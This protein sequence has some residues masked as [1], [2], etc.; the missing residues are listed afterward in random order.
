MTD[1]WTPSAAYAGGGGGGVDPTLAHYQDVGNRVRVLTETSP[2]LADQ[3]DALMAL[4]Q[5]ATLDTFDL[6][7]QSAAMTARL[8]IDTLAS[9]LT[10]MSAPVQRSVWGK[11]TETQQRALAEL[12]YSRPERDSNRWG[13]LGPVGAVAGE[14]L[15][16]LGTAAGAAGGPV[17]DALTFVGDQSAHMYRTVAAM[18]EREQQ[19]GLFAG[20]LAATGIAAAPF[21]G[22]LSLGLT[23]AAVGGGGLLAANAAVAFTNP[24]DWWDSFNSTWDGER[25]FSLEAQRKAREL[26]G[27]DPTLLNLAADIGWN[28]DPYELVAEFAAGRDATGEN[29]LLR[30]V[31]RVAQQMLDPS[32]P[33][34]RQLTEGLQRLVGD[35][36]FH[37]AIQT[38][39]DG[40]ISF[41][42]SIAN[43]GGLSP[44]SGMYNVVS[45]AADGLWL[46]TMDPTLALGKVG[47]W[48]KARRFGVGI[49]GDMTA[50]AASVVQRI[51]NN[52]AISRHYDVL[53]DAVNTGDF[54][55]VKQMIPS[56]QPLWGDLVARRNALA[57]DGALRGGFTSDDIYEWLESG[58]GMISLL[59]GRAAVQGESKL[60]LPTLTRAG[61]GWGRAKAYAE[62][63]INFADD[64][65]SIAAMRK[66]AGEAE[67]DLRVTQTAATPDAVLAA[68]EVAQPAYRTG[69]RVASQADKYARTRAIIDVIDALPGLNKIE[70]SFG[71]LAGSMTN[72]IPPSRAI[73]LIDDA[74]HSATADIDKFVDL[75]RVLGMKSD[76]RNAWRNFIIDQPNTALRASAIESYLD[77]VL[78]VTGAGALPEGDALIK[79]FLTKTH[80]SYA[81]GGADQLVVGGR[82]RNTG[83]LPLA[84]QAVE[85]IMPDLR[86]LRQAVQKGTVLH[87]LLDAGDA[88]F[89]DSAMTKVWK[90][91]VLLRIGFIPR[92]AGEELLA[93]FARSG[94]S[95]FLAERAQVSVAQG[96]LT[97]P[98][99]YR[100]QAGREILTETDLDLMS[101]W[102]VA[103]HV[104]PLERVLARQDWGEPVVRMLEDYSRTL[105]GLLDDGIVSD[106]LLAR[107]PDAAREK[108]LG[109]ERGLRRLLIAGADDGIQDAVQAFQARFGDSIMRTVGAQNAGLLDRGQ[110]NLVHVLTEGS[111][112]PKAYVMSRG[113]WRHYDK[114]DELYNTAYHHQ[115]QRAFGDPVVAQAVIDPMTR[116]RP[117]FADLGEDAAADLARI[118]S[119]IDPEGPVARI[120]REGLD[121]APMSGIEH[122]RLLQELS[123]HLDAAQ[124]DEMAA[125][126]PTS[127][128]TAS[129]VLDALATVGGGATDEMLAARR[130]LDGLDGLGVETR[131]WAQAFLEHGRWTTDD[132]DNIGEWFIDD[133]DDI[134]RTNLAALLTDPDNARALQSSMFTV[135][136]PTGGVVRNP[137][138]N[139]TVRLYQPTL[140]QA[141][142]ATIRNVARPAARQYE[143]ALQADPDTASELL[144]SLAGDILQ[145]W[146]PE[147]ARLDGELQDAYDVV[148][149]FTKAMILRSGDGT[150]DE[151]IAGAQAV[152]H[153]PLAF[154]GFDDPAIARAV[155]FYIKRR[156]RQSLTNARNSPV[157][158]VDFDSAMRAGRL[159]EVT[160]RSGTG[161]RNGWSTD[162]NVV[163]HRAQMV[164]ADEEFEQIAGQWVHGTSLEESARQWS[165]TINER[166][167][168]I[169]RSDG[170]AEMR[171]VKPL[172]YQVRRRGGKREWVEVNPGQ[173]LSKDRQYIDADGK[174]VK[175]SDRNYMTTHEVEKADGRL[176]W[177]ILGP[178]LRDA[179]DEITGSTLAGPAGER[180][181][182]SK[183]AHIADAN[184]DL[185]QWAIDVAMKPVEEGKWDRFVRF[186]YDQVISP[187]IDAIVR[188]PMALHYWIDSYTQASKA[189]RWMRDKRII[190]D[191]L[192]ARFGSVFSGYAAEGGDD[193]M[194]T[195]RDGIALFDDDLADFTDL[196]IARYVA[197]LSDV[198]LDRLK[199]RARHR[200][201]AGDPNAGRQVATINAIRNADPDLLR[202]FARG[203]DP[204]LGFARM[205]IDKAGPSLNVSWSTARRHNRVKELI[206][207]Y[208]G[209]DEA[210]SDGGWELVKAA[211]DNL[212]HVDQLVGDI[213]I[214]RTVA[215]AM[216][217]VDSHAIKS[218]FSAYGRN[219][220]PFWYAE[221]NFIK[222]WARTLRIAPEALRK[223]QL[224][225]MGMKEVG[226]IRSDADGR[227]WFVYPGSGPFI[228]A[229]GKVPG[230]GALPIGA[231]MQAETQNMLPGFNR[232][233]QPSPSPLVGVPLTAITQ[234]FPELRPMHEAIA[235]EKGTYRGIARQVIPTT[236]MRVWEAFFADENTSTAYASA[237]NAAIAYME[238]AGNGVPDNA[239]AA[240]IDDFMRRV[241]KHARTIMFAQA[242]GG[243]IVPGSPRT[244]NTGTPSL[245]ESWTGV[246]ADDP[247][248]LI[249]EEYYTLIRQMG[250]EEGTAA[251]LERF[252]DHGLED[253]INPMALTVSQSESTSGA[254]LPATE[255]A[256]A[257]YDEHAGWMETLPNAGPWLLPPDQDSTDAGEAYAYTRQTID[258]L[259]LRR[260]P[261]EYLRAIKFKEGGIEYFR[262]MDTRDKLIAA[263]EAAG[264]DVRKR[265]AQETWSQFSDVHLARHPVF[266]EEL[267]SSDGRLRRQRVLAEMRVAVADPEAPRA[268]HFDETRVAVQM[269]DAYQGA[270]A[271]LRMDRT[272]AG[273]ERLAQIKGA[274]D[275]TMAEFVVRYPHMESLWISV[276]RPEANL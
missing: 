146:A 255:Q 21:T 16:V 139:N 253:I 166:L 34:Y 74:K 245:V 19:I 91:A 207:Q 45:G 62:G 86:E 194:R 128:A 186:G 222:R 25:V 92:A 212:E 51:K 36:D 39:Q 200:L 99:T 179:G 195:V 66:I 8:R 236:G 239:G 191:M 23:A 78:R 267:Q 174:P 258:G 110:R 127:N 123:Y 58:E 268:W 88:K 49:T 216:Q 38:L 73:S 118:Y 159:P 272:N 242:I 22:G 188:K 205:L 276:L 176:M 273:Q 7:T 218:Q 101:H 211:R 185:P 18:D 144:D 228:E 227:D 42:R 217:F 10:S 96:A 50:D 76:V 263:A 233:G 235:G 5:D 167:G 24:T 138:P 231:M 143:A 219:F 125:I 29:Q 244:L 102:R 199:A 169:V 61:V 67:A 90:P 11:L 84:D 85:L 63:V 119:Q 71:A 95:Q 246:G 209:F 126:L 122:D 154:Y 247:S 210:M 105:R 181:F 32:D 220:L 41:G 250:I 2:W 79:R 178:A 3:P 1:S 129:E 274:Y 69:Q 98:D 147:V 100:R 256:V 93:H 52:P 114:G 145:G 193:F 259:R 270:I 65:N 252:P 265:L 269:F 103:A 168:Q 130:L 190:D 151:L 87:Y 116:A 135:E 260:T 12:G 53:A 204:N 31:D 223:G 215:A 196:Q 240:E 175:W 232:F 170:L 162:H 55:T 33:R 192:P 15:G 83:V 271:E 214:E 141:D 121:A 72:M 111:D 275:Q 201:T 20:V 133:V 14:G 164:P 189:S 107:L 161:G 56:S 132:L 224:T 197:D 108:L 43:R 266:A 165:D 229:L 177:E 213:A 48:N 75:G 27:N 173:R 148:H 109:N 104:R 4:A 106:G 9:S 68:S 112:E 60:M 226:A 6:A 203:D 54:A 97:D 248:A 182:R 158:Y 187:S 198:E 134:V 30:S 153:V 163:R 35:P 156:N 221:E 37:E 241:E 264:D 77:T 131:G 238:A 40:K 230:L 261:E 70:R 225:Y 81:L 115:L 254:R 251:Y 150:L 206:E 237:M 152:G 57:R 257:F 82:V 183:L 26:L 46:V 155:S 149:D 59:R 47:Q 13:F 113:E 142:L 94:I 180:I 17:L 249:R 157:A 120:V 208:P 137:L 140:T 160:K 171:S 89:I 234:T 28:D 64:N 172:R 80:Q 117:A 44:N 202:T 243:F 262:A 184:A 124:M 136:T